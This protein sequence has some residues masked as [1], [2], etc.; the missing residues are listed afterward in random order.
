GL[1]RV[2]GPHALGTAAYGR[3]PLA[4]LAGEA[5]RPVAVSAAAANTV[6]I[7]LYISVLSGAPNPGGGA[8]LSGAPLPPVSGWNVPAVSIVQYGHDNL[9]VSPKTKGQSSCRSVCSVR[10][11]GTG[12]S[13]G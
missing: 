8:G 5:S 12:R 11:T 4:A 9:R 6:A 10:I 13:S 2:S 1:T 3:G 7:R